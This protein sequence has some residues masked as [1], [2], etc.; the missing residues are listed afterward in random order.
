M[1]HNEN[2]TC[3]TCKFSERYTQA[4]AGVQVNN[5]DILLCR[6]SQ[7]SIVVSL[8]HWCSRWEPQE[9]SDGRR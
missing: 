2:E 1:S 5:V 6:F 4:Y 3:Q 8:V 7:A 9:V